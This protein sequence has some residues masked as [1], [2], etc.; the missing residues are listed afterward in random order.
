MGKSTK[1]SIVHR[2]M[3]N[4]TMLYLSAP[5]QARREPFVYLLRSALRM[6]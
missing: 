1:V 5:T 3:L 6:S 2:R 4:Q